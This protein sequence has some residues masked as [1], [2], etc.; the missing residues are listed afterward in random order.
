[1]A[2]Q[3]KVMAVRKYR[4]LTQATRPATWCE[5]SSNPAGVSSSATR[6]ESRFSPASLA[7]TQEGWV[8][9]CLPGTALEVSESTHLRHRA[10]LFEN[11]ENYEK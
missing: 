8:Q 10:N 3:G 5:L 11:R 6:N 7:T 1:M 9:L 2:T 4:E